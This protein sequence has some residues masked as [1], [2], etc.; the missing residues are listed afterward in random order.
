MK[1]VIFT[2][3]ILFFLSSCGSDT[4]TE[5][6]HRASPIISEGGTHIQFPEAAHLAFFKTEQLT[7]DTQA[8]KFS[9]PANVAATVVASREGA[10]QNL[11]LFENPDLASHYTQLMQ[12]QI[13][14]NQIANVNLKQRQLELER[15]QD[16]NAHGVAT[17][18]DLLDAQGALSIEQSQLSNEKAALIEHESQLISAGFT[19]EVLR[20]A[21]AGTAFLICD[22]PEN[23]IDNIE[24]D[25]SCDIRF[26]AFPNT[27]FTGKV[28]AIADVVD[29]TTRMI[30]ARIIVNNPSKKIKSGMF[31]NVTF[32]MEDPHNVSI[33]KNALVTVQGQHYVFVKTSE[34]QF[35]RRQVQTGQPIGDRIIVFEGISPDD[36]VAVEGVLQL[37][38]LSFGY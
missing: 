16:L 29:H 20:K 4:K 1:H 8:A 22:L 35:E 14:I 6:I 37:K 21:K 23:K 31:A 33:D 24:E 5:Q 32:E 34:N 28:D 7:S 19:P 18:Q 25:S 38:G 17:G 36:E 9:A 13:S 12:L 11:I 26:N 3:I 10:N 2:G 27:E 15:T 30:K